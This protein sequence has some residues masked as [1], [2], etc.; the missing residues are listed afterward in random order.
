MFAVLLGVA[1]AMFAMARERQIVL[2][3]PITSPM[4]EYPPEMLAAG[5]GGVVESIVLVN[6][7]GV[8]EDVVPVDAP[9]ESF[10][11]PT[12]T[13]LRKWT[14]TPTMA[15]GVPHGY[16]FI[17]PLEF[18]NGSVSAGPIRDEDQWDVLPKL[19]K[20]V[21]PIYPKELVNSGN[22]GRVELRVI[23]DKQ[24][25]VL[26]PRVWEAT[27]PAFEKPAIDAI[28][29]WK[30]A[31]AMAKGRPIAIRVSQG[32][33]FDLGVGAGVD[34]FKVDKPRKGLMPEALQVDVNPKPKI[35]VFVV[36]PYD[37]AIARKD[38]SATVQI[39]VAPNG[40]VAMTRILKASEPEFGLALAAALE[41]WI[42]EPALRDKKPATA[43][44]NREHRFTLGDRDSA[45]DSETTE[46]AK[47]IQRGRFS[48][49][50][51][52]NLDAPLELRFR[53]PPSYPTVLFEKGLVG[54][55]LIEVIVD[56]KGR[57]V[58]PRIVEASEPEFGWAAA[59]AAQ[60]WLFN[61]PAVKGKPVEVKVM[62]PFKFVPPE[63]EPEEE[64][65]AN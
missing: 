11:I 29:K 32:I 9:D 35:T 10:K 22:R 23:I 63:P 49:T 1:L 20:E 59:T 24:G 31:P 51:P 46:I 38:G 13:A 28:L 60:R 4:P 25:N 34:A 19:I 36:H 21:E 53:A 15:D 26:T 16:W 18:S 45:L 47:R 5:R 6:V 42:F 50:N 37:R 41:A 56:K 64:V 30:F 3:K 40:R 58:L 44:L 57:A 17:V 7:D 2:A 12:A 48:S 8:V 61:P 62:I 33:T 43:L 54:S 55:A 39:L 52:S 14:F 65:P 27:H